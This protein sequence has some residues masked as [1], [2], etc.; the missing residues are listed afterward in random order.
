[1]VSD[2]GKAGKG[3]DKGGK[4]DSKALADALAVIKEGLNSTRRENEELQNRMQDLQGQ[5][6][7]P[8]KLVQL[9]D[10]QLAKLQGQLGAEDQGVARPNVALPDAS[11]PNAAM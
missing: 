6:D 2:K 8:Q 3:A 11:R 5:L 10:T 9:K 7:K 1:M 4:D